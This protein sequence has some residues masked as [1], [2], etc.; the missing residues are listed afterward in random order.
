MHC[1]SAVESETTT[2]EP[3]P[4]RP[5]DKEPKTR[6]HE[7]LWYLWQ[8]EPGIR[9]FFGTVDHK[10]LGKRYIATAFFFLIAGGLLAL[11]MRLQ[12]AAPQSR[13]LGPE[14][15]NQ[16]F[17]MHGTVMIFW[18]AQPILSG[19]MVF[20]LPMLIGA[21]DL[22]F[23]RLNAFTYWTFLASGLFLFASFFWGQAPD[24]GWFA[25][26]PFSDRMYSPGMGLD[27]YALALIFF[28]ISSTG[29]AINFICTIFRHRAPGMHIKKMPVA[30]YSTLT[31]SIVSIFGMPPLTVALIFLELQRQWHF[32]FFDPQHG[33][34]TVMWQHLF[35]FFGHPWVYVIFLPATGF[36]SMLLPVFSRRPIV[37]YKWVVIS[38]VMTGVIG[39]TVWVHHMFAA[40]ENHGAMI[41]FSAASMVISIFSAIQFASW[42]GTMVRGRPVFTTSMW[43]AIAFLAAFVIGGFSGVITAIVPVDWQL[44]DTYWVVAHI[45]YVLIGANVFPV[46]AAIY[47]WYPKMFGRLMNERLGKVSALLTF[48]GFMTTFFPMHIL[49]YQ[50][51][52]RRVFT[53]GF[54]RPWAIWNAIETVGAFMLGAGF[55]LTLIN[56]IVSRKYGQVA[57]K[58]PWNADTL[59]WDT[60]S[61]PPP[62]NMV[63]LPT[64]ETLHPLWDEHDET[65]DP[66]NERVFDQERLTFTTTPIA[67]EPVAVAKIPGDTLMPVYATIA[68]TVIFA[69]LLVK[70]VSIAVGFSIISGLFIAR[71]MWPKPEKH[72]D[73]PDPIAPA[74]IDEHRGSSGMTWLIANEA[75]LFA[76]LF[77][78]YYYLG[79]SNP[80]WPLDKA[81]KWEMPVVMTLVLFVSNVITYIS[82]KSYEKARYPLARLLLV[83]AGVLGLAFVALSLLDMKHELKELLPT[84]DSYGSI[85]YTIV[86]IHL[87]HVIIGLG[88]IFWVVLQPRL[89]SHKPPH[90]ALANVAMYWHF[91][92]IVWWVILFALYLVPNWRQ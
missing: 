85:L 49:G 11:L 91:V 74:F 73:S 28:T 9:G 62:Y 7:R 10:K 39:F 89:K 21:R 64:V 27:F 83:I 16:V 75:M 4:G 92:D 24:A 38:T 55:M 52:P 71:W 1:A 67:A 37:G 8:D 50:G 6:I 35:W 20:V 81:P 58:N 36:I 65:H 47:Y 34:S 77:F 63:H 66:T 68:M 26:T 82:R 15:Y 57:G 14:A 33:G 13:V 87:A 3:E 51:M 86:A 41:Y 46:M 78:A 90:N 54:D 5:H 59:E 44:T 56:A 42:I 12:L 32:H 29:G 19:I 45:H 43:F 69:T 84:E 25:Y 72:T 88:M 40:G 48:V 30:L 17:T 70:M 31:S 60:Q 53:Y 79:S 2:G 76:C 23:P 61:P 80:M 22:A 18:Y